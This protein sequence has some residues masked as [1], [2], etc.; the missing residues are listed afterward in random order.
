MVPDSVEEV[1]EPPSQ[2]TDPFEGA[3]VVVDPAAEENQDLVGGQEE[4]VESEVDAESEDEQVSAMSKRNAL[5]ATVHRHSRP[6]TTPWYLRLL[7]TLLVLVGS[8]AIYNY[9]QESSP[10]G[11]CETGKATNRVLEAFKT[12]WTAI[13]SCNRENR[14]ALFSPPDPS[15]IQSVLPPEPSQAPEASTDYDPDAKQLSATEPCPPLPLIPIPHPDTCTPCPAHASC[16]PSTMTC[17]NGFLIRPHP[18]LFFLPLP[19][20][21]SPSN[22]NAQNSYT[23]PSHSEVFAPSSD[24][25]PQLVSKYV[26]LL[27]DG[28]PGLGSVALPPR[29]VEDPRRKRLIGAL[30]RG[31]ESILAAERGR[32]LCAGIGASG[33]AGSEAEEAKKWGVEVDVLKE[34]L[35]KKTSVSDPSSVLGEVAQRFELDSAQFGSEL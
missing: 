5:D 12:R 29:C 18:L 2:E 23:I 6:D 30:G 17:D 11:F 31:V 10:V 19:T 1:E 8:G 20:T 4:E 25:I 16:S 27:L 24:T 3:G 14:T 9:K 7:F 35:R 33:P 34:G 22:L 13:E 21:P 15:S 28:L 26:A 32:R